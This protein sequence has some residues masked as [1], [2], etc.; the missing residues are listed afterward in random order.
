MLNLLYTKIANLKN[1]KAVANF[2]S[3]VLAESEQIMILRRLQIAKMLL[4]G[5]TYYNIKSKL[6]VGAD[7]IK[8][9]RKKIDFGKGGY[10]NFIKKLQ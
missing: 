2:L 1:R 8:T 7:N 5:E 10:I 9:V 6:N 3:D 4:E